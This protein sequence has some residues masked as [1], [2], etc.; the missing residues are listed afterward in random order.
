[1]TILPCRPTK[2]S[3]TQLRGH[4]ADQLLTSHGLGLLKLRI[5]RHTPE[6]VYG[7]AD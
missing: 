3:V 4:E 2:R 7:P 5:R 1:M 6:L